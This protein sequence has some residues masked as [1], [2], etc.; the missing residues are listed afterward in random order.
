[1]RD[2]DHILL[3]QQKISTCLRKGKLKEGYL[4]L[5]EHDPVITLGKSTEP[6][7]VQCDPRAGGRT[8]PVRSIG[9]G[10]RATLHNPGQLVGYFVC[11]VQELDIN[12]DPSL[13]VNAIERAIIQ[14]LEEFG[15]QGEQRAGARGVWAGGKKL[16]FI[17]LE[18]DD[19]QLMHG[20]AVNLNN[21]M[22][23]FAYILPCGFDP[24]EITSVRKVSG[25][26]VEFWDFAKQLEQNLGA[27][28]NVLLNSATYSDLLLQLNMRPP[29]LTV[30]QFE[31]QESIAS[32]E[33][34]DNLGIN[35]VCES[36]VCPNRGECYSHQT[37][38]FLLLGNCCSRH[39]AFCAVPT[40]SPGPLDPGEISRVVQAVDALNLHYV[41]LTSV[42]RD[43]LPGGGASVF[44]AVI[45]EIRE[46]RPSVTVEVL[47]P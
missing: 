23:D 24:A 33:I 3:V 20:F 14:T 7:D 40:G 26:P 45:A 36:A 35:T 28:L 41:V 18:W 29:W 19:Q 43:D 16:G 39:C 44:A 21:D 17:G 25:A 27:G 8:I 47:I 31:T 22:D 15:I 10:G 5:G 42:T 34:L 12:G 38:T 4:L 37:A 1:M 30:S 46:Q 32:K 6:G 9:R 2:Y 11:N 13:L